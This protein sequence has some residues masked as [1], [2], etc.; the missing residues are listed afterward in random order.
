MAHRSSKGLLRQPRGSQSPLTCESAL[1]R[2]RF[3]LE[4]EGPKC[5]PP[6]SGAGKRFF[7]ALIFLLLDGTCHSIIVSTGTLL[8]ANASS[9][10]LGG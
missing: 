8:E 9:G 4:L 5:L 7:G 6:R 3:W 2:T 10:T 1:I